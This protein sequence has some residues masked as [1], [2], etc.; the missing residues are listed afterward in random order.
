[1]NRKLLLVYLACFAGT[2]LADA[3]LPPPTKTVVCSHSGEFCAASDPGTQMTSITRRGVPGPLWAIPGWQR[4]LIVTDDGQRVVIGYGGLNLVPKEAP[5]STPVPLFYGPAGLIK[6]VTLG[7]LYR[8]TAEMTETVSHYQ[9]E[10]AVYLDAAGQLVV[11]RVDG[12]RVAFDP[13]NGAR[14]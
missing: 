14:L 4:W 7:D 13:N 1:M 9:W 2:A 12:S 6:S 3:P 8:S 10:Q 5:L 11:E